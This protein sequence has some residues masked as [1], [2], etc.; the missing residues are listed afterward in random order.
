MPKL[1]T[2]AK[3]VLI[4]LAGAATA[5]AQLAPSVATLPPQ[6]T[7]ATPEPVGA[8]APSPKYVGPAPGAAESA[9][10]GATAGGSAAVASSPKYT[11]SAP[12][13]PE[14]A[15]FAASEKPAGYDRSATMRPYTSSGMGPKP[16]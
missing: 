6:G 1:L 15:N 4:L 3:A 16:N 12:G 13:G 2:T 10:F 7:V 14:S 8:V 5:Q 11:G 9:N